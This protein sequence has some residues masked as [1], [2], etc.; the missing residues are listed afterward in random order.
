MLE[1]N[2]ITGILKLLNNFQGLVILIEPVV[3]EVMALHPMAGTV[4]WH[5]GVW[6]AD[7]ILPGGC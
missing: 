6:Q 3:H 4:R 1:S 5:F 2:E 7:G